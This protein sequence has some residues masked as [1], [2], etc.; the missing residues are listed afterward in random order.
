LIQILW[1]HPLLGKA[2]TAKIRHP[3]TRAVVGDVMGRGTRA[4]VPKTASIRFN[5]RS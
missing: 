5:R 2:Q 1:I 4:K 3:D